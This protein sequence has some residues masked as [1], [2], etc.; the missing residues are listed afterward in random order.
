M[1]RDLLADIEPIQKQPKD[2]LADIEPLKNE[3]GFGSQ[4][5]GDA[6]NLIIGAGDAINSA[7][8]QLANLLMPKSMQAKIPHSGEGMAYDTGHFGGDLAGFLLGGN[9][10]NAA[11]GATEAAPL[12]GKAAEWLGGNGIGQ[13]AARLGIGSA[14]HGAVMNPANREQGAILGGIGGY[15]GGALGSLAAK[16]FNPATYLKPGASIGKINENARVAGNTETGLGDVI[17]SPFLKRLYEN[18]ISKNPF[19]GADEKSARVGQA[20]VDKQNGILSKYLGDT[21]PEQVSDK[22][23]EGLLAS[24]KAQQKIKND[25][26]KI[27]EQLAD[28]SNLEMKFPSFSENVTKYGDLINDKKFLQYEPNIKKIL[29]D[30]ADY[31]GD[32]KLSDANFLASKLNRL[33]KQK[34]A[35][36]NP[37]DREMSRIFG[38]LGGSLKTDIRESIKNS[39]NSDLQD[40]FRSAEENYKKNFVPF[41]DKDIYKFTHG[42]KNPEDI[43]QNFIKTGISSDKARPIQNL[44]SKLDPETQGLVKYSYLQRALRG[45]EN[46]RSADPDAFKTLWSDTKLG[47]NQKKSLFPDASERQ[48]LDDLSKLTSMNSDA[49]KRMFNPLTGQRGLEAAILGAHSAIGGAAGYHEGGLPGL[50]A[51]I[52]TGVIAPSIAARQLTK[53]LTSPASRQKIIGN[54]SSKK[55]QSSSK[56]GAMGAL[57]M[58]YL[59][60]SR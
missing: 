11:R 55:A 47:Q 37:D 4:M 24:H 31:K 8:A 10:L 15:A 40:S 16:A 51:G 36:P 5:L 9:L 2:L 13:T 34:G 22:I 41:L 44:M 57:L 35:S 25:L 12:I 6:A 17:E 28:S 48:Q 58:Q 21:P 52:G 50:L 14:A 19:S 23:A 38:E 49:V 45:S 59:L 46:D 32:V 26:Y 39:G 27:P 33:S 54:L 20:I 60:N 3:P 56:T 7:P 42:G 29:N 18:Y 43:V 30:V 1:P 53:V